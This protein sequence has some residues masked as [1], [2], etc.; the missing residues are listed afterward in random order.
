MRGKGE[1]WKKAEDEAMIEALVKEK[2]EGRMSQNGFGQ[3][4]WN[5]VVSALEDEGYSRTDKQ[6]KNR[7]QKV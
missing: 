3:K 6:C 5:V 7:Y 2:C 4:C 1:N